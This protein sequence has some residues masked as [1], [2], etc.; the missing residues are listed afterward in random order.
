LSSSGTWVGVL[1]GDL[2]GEVVG[3]LEHDVVV[4]PD[5]LEHRGQVVEAVG[6]PAPHRQVQ[7]D[8][9]GR[10]RRD[11]VGRTAGRQGTLQD[12]LRCGSADGHQDRQPTAVAARRAKSSTASTSPRAPGSMPAARS[13]LS[14]AAETGPAGQ[15]G[16][17]RL[18]PLGEGGVHD[19]E[20][21][22]P[23]AERR[24]PP[25]EGDQPESTCGAGQKTLRPMEPARRTSAYQA[26]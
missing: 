9:G 6:P 16:A 8:L 1:A 10:A 15:G 5:G 23:V 19:R 25:G 13:R 26:P 17:Q 11:A 2:D 12:R 4:Q 7:V 3:P 21:G 20:G 22:Q 18:A 24:L 14:A